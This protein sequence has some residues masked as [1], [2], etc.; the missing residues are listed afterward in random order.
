MIIFFPN[1]EKCCHIDKM[2]FL[3]YGIRL[4]NI[5]LLKKNGIESTLVKNDLLKMKNLIFLW[6]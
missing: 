4:I 3:I 5:L 2:E 1:L 6:K